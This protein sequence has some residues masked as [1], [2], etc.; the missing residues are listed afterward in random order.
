MTPALPRRLAGCLLALA[1]S[2]TGAAECTARSGEWTVPLLELYTSEGC[3]SCPP[4]DRLLSRLGASAGG[5]LV[6][7]AL[8]VDYWDAIGWADPYAQPAFSAR[9]RQQ[10]QRVGN[11]VV[12]TPQFF[13]QGNTGRAPPTAGELAAT[14]AALHRQP[15]RADIALSVA[16]AGA[17]KVAVTAT[18]RL[19]EAPP[20]ESFGLVVVL[21]ENGLSTAVKAGENRGRT[22]QHDFVV[23]AWHEAGPVPATGRREA[24]HQFALP[25]GART[26]QLGVAALVDNR[27]SGEVIQALARSLCQ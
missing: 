8:H 25:A 5:R 20:G 14:L 22:L 18:A 24:T 2:T 3:S 6:P 21:Y 11:R 27:R 1:A 15:A 19:R 12:Y 13:V 7:L 9:Q 10:A 16:D 17:Q 23:R 26:G 4:A